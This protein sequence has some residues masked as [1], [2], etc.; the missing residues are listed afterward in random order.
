MDGLKFE[1][2]SNN[3][4]T[5]RVDLIITLMVHT[6]FDPLIKGLI[7]YTFNISMSPSHYLAKKRVNFYIDFNSIKR[8]NSSNFTLS[9]TKL[10]KR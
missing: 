7:V 9:S 6:M 1:H 5:K 10:I 3:Y 8:L 2:N 4:V